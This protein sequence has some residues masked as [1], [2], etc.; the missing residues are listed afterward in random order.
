[1]LNT[2]VAVNVILYLF[3]YSLLGWFVETMYC[4][5]LSGKFINRGFINGPF[6]PIY[7]F[8]ALLI[9]YLLKPVS[10]SPFLVFVCGMVITSTLEYITSILMEYMFNARW[11]D[12]SDKKYNIHGRVCL[13]NSAMFGVLCVFTE[14]DIHPRI[15]GLINS[16][17]LDF[18]MG[19]MVALL[20]Y[21]TVDFVVTVYTVL[22][23]NK[24]VSIIGKIK[25][26]LTEAYELMSEKLE[27]EQIIQQLQEKEAMRDERVRFLKEKVNN[28]GLFERRL[29]KAFPQVSFKKNNESLT[30]IKKKLFEKVKEAVER[31]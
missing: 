21:F 31:D 19:F 29:L 14:F 8:G 1:M 16:V 5:F 26:E 3:I 12:Y 6:C 24:K 20:M 4:S 15:A 17:S 30:E 10:T 25:Q 22:G 13:Q 23:L 28:S 7:G 2:D 9:L 11:W 18:K 27:L